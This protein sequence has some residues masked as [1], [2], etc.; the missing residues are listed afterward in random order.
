MHA[1][2]FSLC[3]NCTGTAPAQ[4]NISMTDILSNKYQKG[5]FGAADDS[6]SVSLM[7]TTNR[8]AVDHQPRYLI[9]T[10]K[11]DRSFYFTWPLIPSEHVASWW[12]FASRPLDFYP[13]IHPFVDP[14]KICKCIPSIHRLIYSSIHLWSKMLPS[15]SRES[16]PGTVLL[17]FAVSLP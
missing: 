12:S 16:T 8:K 17:R 14:V 1:W 15:T 6:D 13:S 2:I 4:M 11:C 9:S 7:K 10:P 3:W 5:E